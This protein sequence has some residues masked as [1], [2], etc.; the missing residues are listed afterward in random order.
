MAGPGMVDPA[1]SPAPFVDVFDGYEQREDLA[2]LAG[3]A[4]CAGLVLLAV[5]ATLS[6]AIWPG[7]PHD[8]GA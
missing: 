1:V 3:G 7:R 6:A 8:P 2:L 5:A 4:G